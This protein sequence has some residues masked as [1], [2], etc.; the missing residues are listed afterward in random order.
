[1]FEPPPG[2]DDLAAASELYEIDEDANTVLIESY[3]FDV[4]RWPGPKSVAALS[5]ATSANA[6]VSASFR[7]EA[8]SLFVTRHL[9]PEAYEK[10]LYMM[11]EGD[12]SKD[13]MVHA[14]RA[15]C[16]A[17]TARPTGPLSRSRG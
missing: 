16:T 15:L 13:A 8:A 7:F 3:R 17:K 9:K 2:N 6:R 11:M 1:M 14:M 4:A 12:L 5:A 10:L